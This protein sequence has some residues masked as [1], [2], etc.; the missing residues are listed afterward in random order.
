[1][2]DFSEKGVF[3]R[4]F[5]EA[6]LCYIFAFCYY[7]LLFCCEINILLAKNGEN[8]VRAH[9]EYAPTLKVQKFNKRP[10]RL[11]KYIRYLKYEN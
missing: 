7:H 1:M 6:V 4:V 2:G 11:I 10:E 8:L 5:T 3:F 9:F